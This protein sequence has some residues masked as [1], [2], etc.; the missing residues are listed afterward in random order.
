MKMGFNRGIKLE[1]HSVKVTTDGGLFA[2]RDLDD[3]IMCQGDTVKNV[4]IYCACNDKQQY[5]QVDNFLA[6]YDTSRFNMVIVI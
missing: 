5:Y 3:A 6:N 2:Y 4:I 1:F